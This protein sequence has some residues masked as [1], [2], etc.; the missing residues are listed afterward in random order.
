MLT[1]Q[2]AANAP[3]SIIDKAMTRKWSEESFVKKNYA[4]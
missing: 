2:I 1:N 4:I 3:L